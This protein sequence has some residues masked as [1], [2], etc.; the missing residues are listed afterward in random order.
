MVVSRKP[1]HLDVVSKA[2]KPSL[3]ALSVGPVRVLGERFCEPLDRCRP[4]YLAVA[5]PRGTENIDESV[6]DFG[7]AKDAE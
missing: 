3:N 7:R 1:I 4:K 6:I 2:V 5:S